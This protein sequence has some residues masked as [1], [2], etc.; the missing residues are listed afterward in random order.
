MSYSLQF[1]HLYCIASWR[2]SLIPTY[3]VYDICDRLL[4]KPLIH[5]IKKKLCHSLALFMVII[6]VF[7]LF[8]FELRF[9]TYGHPYVIVLEFFISRKV[10]FR[11]L[12]SLR[13]TPHNSCGCI[14]ARSECNAGRSGDLRSGITRDYSKNPSSR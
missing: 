13:T 7:F 9:K 11:T 12:Q 1:P 4:H 5:C 6:T 14:N 2:I 3:R 8:L 10:F